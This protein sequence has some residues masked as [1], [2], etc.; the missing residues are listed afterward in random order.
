MSDPDIRWFLA[1]GREEDKEVEC[2]L[3]KDEIVILSVT[4]PFGYAGHITFARAGNDDLLG[5]DLTLVAAMAL[6]HS[7]DGDSVLWYELSRGS[8]RAYLKHAQTIL[9]S[10][11]ER[12]KEKREE[13]GQSGHA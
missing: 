9:A 3:P 7:V 8:Q 10:V 5:E 4:Q 6:M 1:E 2:P 11:Q 12:L 13:R